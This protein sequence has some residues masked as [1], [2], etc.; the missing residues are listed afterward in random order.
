MNPI[1]LVILNLEEIRRRSLIIWD[2]LPTS[3][4]QWKPDDTAMSA[5]E[6]V[7]HVAGADFGWNWILNTNGNMEGYSSPYDKIELID[8]ETEMRH[9]KTLRSNLYTTI[10][11]FSPEDLNSINIMHPGTG[12]TRKLGD[13]L[14]RIGYHESVHAGQ[15]LSYFRGMAL[16]R[17]FIWD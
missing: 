11:G 17:P 10:R 4:Y 6:L 16:E 13:Y 8:I 9:A 7:R 5:L 12:G 15:L 1:D 3:Y 2:S 14:L